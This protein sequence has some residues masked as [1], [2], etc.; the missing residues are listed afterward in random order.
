MWNTH[1]VVYKQHTGL[2]QKC[3]ESE[4]LQSPN[5]YLYSKCHPLLEIVFS[6]LTVMVDLPILGFHI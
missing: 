5:L 3:I 4:L 2:F 1:L 6:E